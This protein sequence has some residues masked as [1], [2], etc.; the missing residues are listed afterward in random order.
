MGTR[1]D[2]YSGGMEEHWVS[3]E[4][5]FFVVVVVC[6][7]EHVRQHL[8]PREIGGVTVIFCHAGI[9]NVW[10]EKLSIRKE[11]PESTVFSV[12]KKNYKP[13]KKQNMRKIPE[14]TIRFKSKMIL[15]TTRKKRKH[16]NQMGFF[17]LHFIHYIHIVLVV[18][19]PLFLIDCCLFF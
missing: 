3:L 9:R 5:E 6:V 4:K 1:C 18:I 11:K 16:Y 8:I 10:R 2:G 13:N 19:C 7:L 17:S 12:K 14:L 15:S